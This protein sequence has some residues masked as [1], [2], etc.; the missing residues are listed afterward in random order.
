MRKKRARLSTC[1][2][3]YLIAPSSIDQIP[4]STYLLVHAYLTCQKPWGAALRSA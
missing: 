1:P 3:Y 2:L 4:P